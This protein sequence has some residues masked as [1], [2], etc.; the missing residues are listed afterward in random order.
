MAYDLYVV[1]SPTDLENGRF[2][3]RLPSRVDFGAPDKVECA[4]I[5]C[6][7]MSPR[8][9]PTVGEYFEFYD[10]EKRNGSQK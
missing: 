6:S 8:N 1:A 10:P 5:N 7:I 9:P 2:T 4:I 3:V